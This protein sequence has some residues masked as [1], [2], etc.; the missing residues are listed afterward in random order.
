M[1]LISQIQQTQRGVMTRQRIM[2]KV[3]LSDFQAQNRMTSSKEK[4]LRVIQPVLRKPRY[5]LFNRKIG[6]KKM[7]GHQLRSP[8]ICRQYLAG[9]E[10]LTSSSSK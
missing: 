8:N 4:G 9:I 3:N 10:V 1:Y 7:K 6:K 2:R 5:A